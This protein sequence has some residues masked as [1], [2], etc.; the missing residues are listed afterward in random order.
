LAR[1]MLSLHEGSIATRRASGAC[2]RWESARTQQ[3]LVVANAAPRCESCGKD[4][5]GGPA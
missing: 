4:T 5:P 1:R 3:P 2:S